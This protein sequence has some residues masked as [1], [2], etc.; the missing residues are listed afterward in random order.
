MLSRY[1][2]NR[3]IFAGVISILIV[4]LGFTA[5]QMLPVSQFPNVTP[6][7][8][9]VSITYPGADAKTISD[10][11]LAPIEA[12]IAGADNLM[13]VS[14]SASGMSGNGRISCTFEVGTDV[15]KALNDIQNRVNLAQPRLPSIV[16]ML[17]VDVK[18]RTQDILMIAA[19]YSPD[20]SMNDI[21]ISNYV[22][23]H[24]INNIKRLHGAGNALISGQRDYSMRIWLNPDKMASM[25]ISTSDIDSAINEQNLQVNPGRLGQSP[26][27]NQQMTVML[28][29]KG[30]LSRVEEFEQIIVRTKPDG[31]VVRLND[32][33]RVE[34]GTSNYEYYGRFNGKPAVLLAV[35]DQS[36]SNAIETVDTVNMELERL[37]KTFPAGLKYQ[38]AHNATKF[39]KISIKEVI[40]TLSEALLLVIIVIYLFLQSFRATIIA[41][42][43]VPV[44]LMG[45][46][47][48]MYLLG[49]SINT[50]TLFGMVLAI[51]IV[52]DDAIVVVE[53]I[54]R[55]IQDENLSPKEAAIKA[56]S[57]VSSPII[58]IVLVLCAVFVPATFV[59]GMTGELYKQFAMTIAVSVVFSGFVALTLSPALGALLLRPHEKAPLPI[60]ARFNAMF[61][62]MTE[63]YLHLSSIMIR[64]S[65]ITL[66]LYL[67]VFVVIYHL[68]STL[69]KSFLPVEDQGFFFTVVSLP[70]GATIE[71]TH[72]AVVKAEN[73]V[74]A[75]AG[76]ESVVTIVGSNFMGGTQEPNSATMIIRL[77]HWD[78]RKS[79][80]LS[81]KSIKKEVQKA[82]DLIKEASFNSYSP[83]PIRGLSKTGG[84]QLWLQSPD[85]DMDLLV[86]AAQDFINKAKEIPQFKDVT[87]SMRPSSPV[88]F[89]DINRERAKILGVSLEDLYS[90][91]QNTIG[92]SNV[93][94][95]V[96][97][98]NTYWIKVQSD[99]DF[100]REPSDIGRG[101]VKSSSG[102]MIP[103]SSLINVEQKSA[104]VKIEH[105]NTTLAVAINVSQKHGV[106]TGEMIT[107]IEELSK[108]SLPPQIT[109][110]WDGIAHQ[111]LKVQDRARSIL[112]FAFVIVF[113]ILAA[114]YE[115]WTLPL[116]VML[117]IPFGMGGAYIAVWLTGQNNDVF[118]QIGL[119]TLVALAAKNAIL[120]IQFAEEERKSGKSVYDATM[121]AARLRYR[122]MMM[123]SLAF[124]FGVL[125][126]AFSTGAGAESRHSIGI[127]IL[128][129][130][131]AATFVERYFIPYLY[132]Q[133]ST[134]R[135]KIQ[136]YKEKQ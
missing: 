56:M 58:A 2:I 133:V 51:G 123:T 96:K 47:I 68:S 20:E 60:F 125:P 6:P 117:A 112:L 74:Q 95:F 102:A 11:V 113:L 1:F 49:Y 36:D 44:S 13:Y 25:G 64:R 12:Q 30:R 45:A 18:K 109:T 127:G 84:V 91:I 116:A 35:Y 129:G 86:Q 59:G 42:V 76:V 33:A 106:S 70:E 63:R 99:G 85:G 65:F 79:D 126:L 122:P 5:T 17:G 108:K 39:V 121:S 87:S 101:Y 62:D 120:V 48:G 93:G 66:M 88:L 27:S 43:A 53:N 80:E 105:F 73:A 100:R 37:S 115:A 34:L 8:V 29:S 135:E 55:I 114:Q 119:L 132:Y 77:A 69:Q 38:I 110:S 28:T 9:G 81:V 92:L 94:Q 128:G 67:S 83:P 10:T 118:F 23:T 97:D 90:T 24:V 71:R 15:D 78:Q 61:A 26:I 103:L 3:P 31:T 41:L 124:V 4:V 14:S 89:I 32:V 134:L 40:K 82:T 7:S 107:L 75:I 130:M 57:Q 50:L 46:F 111:Q 54:E 136:R 98:G 21:E 72:E 131:I 19:L 22:T 104:A 52:V 16:K